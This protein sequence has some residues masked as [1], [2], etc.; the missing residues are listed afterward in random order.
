[1]PHDAGPPGDD[2]SASRP[3]WFDLELLAVVGLT[4]VLFRGLY[5]VFLER[6]LLSEEGYRQPVLLV[7]LLRLPPFVVIV[8]VSLALLAFD[9]VPRARRAAPG[10][11]CWPPFEQAPSLRLLVG[12]VALTL[13]WAFSTY[14]LN[15]YLDQAHVL[16]RVLIVV[17][18]GLVFVHPAFVPLFVA[19]TAGVVHQLDMP[20][21]LFSYSWTDKKL[22][23]EVLLLFC[24]FSL[25]RALRPTTRSNVFLF[26]TLCLVAS[27]YVEPGLGK[28]RLGWV[29]ANQ[30]HHLFVS[31]WLNGWLRF[32]D[33]EVV[34]R[35]AQGLAPADVALQALTL[36]IE[37]GAVALLWHKRLTVLFLVAF[38]FLHTAIYAL[39]GFFFWKWMALHAL[40]LALLWRTADTTWLDEIFQRRFL[41]L[42]LVIVLGLRWLF[43]PGVLAWFD[44]PVNNFYELEAVD[45]R[46]RSAP[47]ERSFFAP[48]DF[49]FVQNRFYF[50][51]DEPVLVNMYGELFASRAVAAAVYAAD[52]PDDVVELKRRHGRKRYDVAVAA[53]F[54]SFVR[55]FV[56]NANRRGRHERPLPLPPAPP[57]H[58]IH[59]RE[60]SYTFEAPIERV[61]V[62]FH[63]TFFD[64][65]TVHR[66][67]RELVREIVIEPDA[68][69]SAGPAG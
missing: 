48:Y 61:R 50:L 53:R 59:A 21:G 46:G 1:M 9:V 7:E 17:L 54:E 33:E 41:V 56:R 60:D 57:H 8:V 15:L 25:V 44:T 6:L 37:L 52:G 30:L 10:R 32:L 43:S 35:L 49:P 65:E 12:G 29:T 51:S 31:S 20:P 19:L 22:L 63:E 64:G 26:L 38:L 67:R 11:L 58:A 4:L 36:G 28:A 13:A 5:C 16:D 34:I 18:A 55:I 3:R 23:F 66:L 68:A 24:A 45:R 47:L 42:S 2:R 62:Y 27:H 40:L 69:P 39:T 14:E